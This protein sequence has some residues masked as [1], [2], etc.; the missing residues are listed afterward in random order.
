MA[1]LA[2]AAAC[3]TASM[4]GMTDGGATTFTCPVP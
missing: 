4:D 2:A 1:L 3:G